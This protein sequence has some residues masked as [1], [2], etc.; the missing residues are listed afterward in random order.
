MIEECQSIFSSFFLPLDG[1]SSTLEELVEQH[2]AVAAAGY[3]CTLCGSLIKVKTNIRRHFRDM[4]LGG[5]TRFHCPPCGHV[6]KNMNSFSSHVSK[7]HREWR[8]IDLNRF[9]MQE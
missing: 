2:V 6:Y 5:L 7:S 1:S 8:G 4:H 9:A 3:L